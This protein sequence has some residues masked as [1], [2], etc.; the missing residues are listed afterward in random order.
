[1]TLGTVRF[2]RHRFDNARLRLYFVRTT[3]LTQ[4]TSHSHPGQRMWQHGVQATGYDHARVEHDCGTTCV[5][6]SPGGLWRV[7]VL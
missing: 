6:A 2:L 5:A 4:R 1:M 3:L 7:L